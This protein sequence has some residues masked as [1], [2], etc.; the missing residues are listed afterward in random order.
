VLGAMVN[1][2]VHVVMYTYYTLA[3]APWIPQSYYL[4]WKKY[5]TCAQM[6]KIWFDKK[7]VNFNY[8]WVFFPLS[9]SILRCVGKCK[10]SFKIFLI[11]LNIK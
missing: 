8:G 11:T 3:A 1:C 5:L 7:K 9:G 2:L 6:V 10:F 4:S